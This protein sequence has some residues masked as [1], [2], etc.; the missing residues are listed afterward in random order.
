MS[1]VSLSTLAG[2]LFDATAFSVM[3]FKIYFSISFKFTSSNSKRTVKLNF[4]VITIILGWFSY[5]F[6]EISTRSESPSMFEMFLNSLVSNLSTTF[7][8]NLL[9]VSPTFWSSEIMASFSI[10]VVLDKLGALLEIKGVII[11]QNVLLSV[12]LRVPILEENFFLSFS[13]NM[14]QKFF[15]AFYKIS[16]FDNFY[17]W[18]I[19]FRVQI[20]L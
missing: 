9:R 10:R 16:C 12:I 18:D 8:K 11:F 15:F 5:F 6:I 3:G 4:S 19:Y 13:Y 7:T 1:D 2:I 20:F 14:L 17:F